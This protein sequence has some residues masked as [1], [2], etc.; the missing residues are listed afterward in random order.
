MI[1]LIPVGGLANRMRTI[2]S[3]LT[4]AR[5]C[6][7]PLR[8]VWFKD[9]GLNCR[10]DQLFRHPAAFPKVK[11]IEA[12]YMDTARYD[13]PR[14][15]NLRIPRLMQRLL[16]D[17]CI[18]EDEVI[19]KRDSGFDFETWV[20]S[21][22]NV[23]VASYISFFPYSYRTLREFFLP[24]TSIQN[25]VDEIACHF[26]AHTTGVH[27]R[28]TDNTHSIH[29]SPLSLFIERIEQEIQADG[30]AKFYLASDSPE[31]KA[32]LAE[33]FGDRI[34]THRFS[35]ERDRPEG[36]QDA[37]AEL[38][39]LSRTH[40]I[41]GSCWSSFSEIAAQLTDIPCIILKKTES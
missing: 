20:K 24:V 7:V 29:L 38:L 26:D 11:V 28:R 16:F 22:K 2:A 3:A 30:Q 35:A 25:K 1:T 13:R 33:R 8:I 12:G 19:R 10:F 36:I 6:D 4:L 23:Y 9:R 5:N 32:E 34:Y 37:L 27:I 21:R 14:K 40:Q 31:D 39:V 17:S 41:I 15:R 18:Y